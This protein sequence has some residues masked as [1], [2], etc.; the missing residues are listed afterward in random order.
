M[1]Y[2]Y[3]G[4]PKLEQVVADIAQ[5]AHSLDL[6]PS[7]LTM[8]KYS[9]NG[10]KFDGRSLKSLGGFSAIVRTAFPES[11]EEENVNRSFLTRRRTYAAKL[12]RQLGDGDYVFNRMR[13]AFA[14]ALSDVEFAVSALKKPAVQ[15]KKAEKLRENVALLS[16]THF[17]LEIFKQEVIVNQYNWKIAARRLGKFVDQVATFKHEHRAQ[18][19][20]LRLCLGGDL[21]QGII[22]WQ[23]DAGTD[24]IT[25]QVVGITSYLIQA[26]DYLRHHY[27]KIVVECTPDNHMRMVH[28]A[29]GGRSRSQKFDNFSTM[30]YMGL[31]AAFRM[32]PDVTIDIPM[33]PITTFNVLGHKYGL[34][35]GDTHINTGN[36]GKAISMKSIADQVLRLNQASPDNA[37]YRVLCLG[38]VH[39]PL[40]TDLPDCQTSIV[41]NGTMSGAD[42]YATS[43]GF[44]SSVPSQTVWEAT[45]DYPIGDFRIIRLADASDDPKFEGIIKP[46]DRNIKI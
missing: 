10:G 8:R 46:Y 6:D 41:I 1:S 19:P 31:Q 11:Y 37:P 27:S 15:T 43:E 26:I 40:H 23:S 35:H 45:A 28:K 29:D 2:K 30:V 39:V 38:H 33:S 20:Q 22:H 14:S 18:C 24:L 36:V 34:T 32:A 9:E 5:V 3:V 4:L 17:G 16:D 21:G 42:G 12:E 13:D 25:H 44:F 7:E